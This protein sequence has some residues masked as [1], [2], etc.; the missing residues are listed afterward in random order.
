M[1]Q[2]QILCAHVHRLALKEA[3]ASL[4]GDLGSGKDGCGGTLALH[5]SPLSALIFVYKLPTQKTNFKT[6]FIQYKSKKLLVFLI[7]K[8][9]HINKYVIS[10]FKQKQSKTVM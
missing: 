5:Y 3:L 1:C 2:K 6:V 10:I 7:F 4:G 8:L 9:K